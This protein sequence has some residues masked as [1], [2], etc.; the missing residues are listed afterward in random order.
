MD[1]GLRLRA[2][3]LLGIVAVDSDDPTLRLRITRVALYAEEQ[4]LRE[5]AADPA[6]KGGWARTALS[7]VS[8]GGLSREGFSEF[9][10]IVFGER[11]KNE[12]D[13][14]LQS[15]IKDY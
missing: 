6:E 2:I 8:A 5:R 10:R 1:L 9:S 3:R 15:D 14:N 7:L 13:P 11:G 4:T 12:E